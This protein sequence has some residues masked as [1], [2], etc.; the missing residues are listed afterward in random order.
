MLTSF[1]SMLTS[2]RPMLPEQILTVFMVPRFFHKSSVKSLRSVF[3]RR[4]TKVERTLYSTITNPNKRSKSLFHRRRPP[5]LL[6]E[7]ECR[8]ISGVIGSWIVAAPKNHPMTSP[9]LGRC[10][11]FSTVRLSLSQPLTTFV[12][13]HRQPRGPVFSLCFT[14]K[15]PNHT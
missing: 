2:R 10:Y 12:C 4:E 3:R 5:L 11:L 1:R 13:Y 8:S 7:S 9:P 14:Q 6:K 15:W